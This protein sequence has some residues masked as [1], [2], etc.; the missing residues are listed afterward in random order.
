MLKERVFNIVWITK[1]RQVAFDPKIV[2]D[3]KVAYNGEKLLVK[4]TIQ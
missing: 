3:N 2:P 1:N 4:K